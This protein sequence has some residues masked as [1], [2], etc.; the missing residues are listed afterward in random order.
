MKKYS[1]ILIVFIVLGSCIAAQDTNPNMSRKS[2]TTIN[3]KPYSQYKA[4]QEAL[5]KQK[6]VQ[7]SFIVRA[8]DNTNGGPGVSAATARTTEETNRVQ[9]AP[10]SH[11]YVPSEQN[12]AYT[13]PV[14]EKAIEKSMVAVKAEAPKTNS[15]LPFANGGG[16]AAAPAPVTEQVIAGTS[17]EAKTVTAS[18]VNRNNAGAEGDG[19]IAVPSKTVKAPAANTVQP[20]ANKVALKGTTMDADAKVVV[21]AQQPASSSLPAQHSGN[22]VQ[23]KTDEKPAKQQ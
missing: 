7:S 6:A 21:A 23:A 1:L 3:G 10:V 5:K 2:E 9:A 4:E 18:A 16:V 19:H 12:A 22:T 17:L 20:D 14:K 11:K 15:S 13:E 8:D